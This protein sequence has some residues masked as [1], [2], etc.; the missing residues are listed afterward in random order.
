MGEQT[1]A[2]ESFKLSNNKDLLEQ[3][4]GCGEE[5]LRSFCYSALQSPLSGA[6]QLIDHAT[7][8]VGSLVG[9]DG[10]TKLLP[11]V[12]FMSA[13]RETV[14][15]SSEWH[16]QQLG[17]A[18]GLAA[19]LV[20]FSLL[21]RRAP[22]AGDTERLTQ[23][24]LTALSR[25]E[26]YKTALTGVVL[27][28]VFTPVKEGDNFWQA[29]G[30]NA[31]VQGL[32]FGT[33]A[34]GTV[35]LRSFGQSLDKGGKW[36]GALLKNEVVGNVLSGIP[37][38]FVHAHCESLL[39][40]KGFAS[41]RDTG[42]SIYTFS[43]VGGLLGAGNIAAARFGDAGT[44]RSAVVDRI[45]EQTPELVAGRNVSVKA[46]DGVKLVEA[47][48]NRPSPE[49][50]KDSS[51][52]RSE[53]PAEFLVNER[54]KRVLADGTTVV[55][56]PAGGSNGTRRILT[57]TDGTKVY[58]RVDGVK[59]TINTDGS[60]VTEYP[61]GRGDLRQVTE[62]LD[63][64]K[65]T[66]FWN[67]EKTSKL[68]DGTVVT[69]YPA[70]GRTITEKPDGTVITDDPVRTVYDIEKLDIVH[71]KLYREVR[72]VQKST[73]KTTSEFPD[74]SRSG[75]YMMV[76][77]YLARRKVTHD[78]PGKGPVIQ[79]E[80]MQFSQGPLSVFEKRS[81]G[82]WCK[83]Y[84]E[85][86][87]KAEGYDFVDGE[88]V[89]F[90]E[91]N[92]GQGSAAAQ[93]ARQQNPKDIIYVR[94]E[95]PAIVEQIYRPDGRIETTY[96]Q[97]SWKQDGQ[98]VNTETIY[99][100]GS[101]VRNYSDSS[102]T[103]ENSMSLSGGITLTELRLNFTSESAPTFELK[104]PDGS[105]FNLKGGKVDRSGQHADMTGDTGR[106][107]FELDGAPAR[108]GAGG[109]YIAPF[110]VYEGKGGTTRYL[111]KD[112]TI[113]TV[114]RDGRSMEIKFA[115]GQELR[116]DQNGSMEV[117]QKSGATHT[118]EFGKLLHYRD[119]QGNR[120]RFE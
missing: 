80:T 31:V 6:A 77:G 26:I 92:E 84:R 48:A 15:G 108:Y 111:Y 29:R 46:Q 106:A 7:A 94:G 76:D 19:D 101:V 22:R 89:R 32:T 49:P 117:K 73:N 11:N 86:P 30:N 85:G 23:T 9:L 96:S 90:I 102:G 64:S 41:L 50:V 18:A 114:T 1:L 24:E 105:V 116:L 28:G 69:E 36:G 110:D 39:S 74:V 112:G 113:A 68:K 25:K 104:G 87:V 97:H 91:V 66:E 63:G 61:P 109:E 54:S 40:G 75:E 81:D 13:P 52:G 45:G 35:G 65:I 93:R 37:A 107:P 72:T 99:P 103:A 88:K 57:K 120:H 8:D 34:A 2:G 60:K 58:E 55:E 4:S 42:K 38:G 62:R 56:F 43:T 83:Q 5:L 12:Q 70:E 20:A 47:V 14:F 17:S 53:V 21:T 78:A 119:A 27:G 95:N 16:A 59:K 10:G 115:D 98:Y 118:T 3:K 79:H 67:G 100:D 33:L 44:S 51:A 82:T 71:E